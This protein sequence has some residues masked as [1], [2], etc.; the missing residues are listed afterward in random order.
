[1]H[2]YLVWSFSIRVFGIILVYHRCYTNQ[3]PHVSLF[4][5]TESILRVKGTI[6]CTAHIF[7]LSLVAIFPLPPKISSIDD[8]LLKG[9]ATYIQA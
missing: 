7:P 1:M 5:H 4:D 6:F 9:K 3:L 8:L 2:N